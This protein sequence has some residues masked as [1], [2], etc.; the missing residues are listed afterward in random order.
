MSFEPSRI[1]TVAG[2]AATRTEHSGASPPSDRRAIT[3]LLRLPLPSTA[4]AACT[5]TGSAGDAGDGSH[6]GSAPAV[7]GVAPATLVIDNSIAAAA[8][9][10]MHSRGTSADAWTLAAG[11]AISD[12][13]AW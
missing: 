1:E 4:I 2:S 11:L 13:V 5:L 7:E 6:E 3:E 10:A 12:W 9:H 8:T